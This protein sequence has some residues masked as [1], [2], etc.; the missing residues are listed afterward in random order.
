MPHATLV[1]HAVRRTDA[2]ACDPSG[3]ARL[4][5]RRGEAHL[6][7]ALTDECFTPSRLSYYRTLLDENESRR[8]D[9]LAIDHVRHEYLL[10]RALCRVSLSHYAD[11]APSAWR[12]VAN[13]YGRPRVAGPELS[14][15]LR[16]NLS[17]SRGLVACLIARDADVGVDVEE[18]TPDNKS[19]IAQTHFSLAEL[20]SM[21]SLPSA[22]QQRRF[23]ELWTL[24]ESYI[25]ARGMGLSLALDQFS[26]D[27]VPGKSIRINFAKMDPDGAAAWQ[28]ELLRP[29]DRHSMAVAIHKGSGPDWPIRTIQT[30]PEWPGT[31]AYRAMLTKPEFVFD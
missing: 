17:N 25:K 12:F 7:Y 26:F 21:A 31:R 16:F 11:V 10:T 30:I 4:N 3:R 1:E 19:E 9:R 24:K 5:L 13:E 22:Q 27:I 20:R 18:I 2:G 29:G 23:F 15:P 8:L 28:F 14:A 6:W